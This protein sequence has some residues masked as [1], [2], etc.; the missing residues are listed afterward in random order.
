MLNV[1]KTSIC[2]K[3]L[4]FY[5]YHGVLEQEKIVGGEYTIDLT[6]D[7]TAPQ[8]AFLEDNLADTIN[9]ADVYELVKAEMKIPVD[10]LE[11]LAYKI[12][13]RLFE[14]FEQI[15]SIKIEVCKINPPLGADTKGASVVL[16]VER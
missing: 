15:E 7:I 3:Q 12:A 5:A 4:Q 1:R 9:Y 6:L 13:E 8:K 10:L 2:L 11:R 14:T 16:Q